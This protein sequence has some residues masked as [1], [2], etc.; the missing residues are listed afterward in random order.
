MKGSVSF[1]ALE[2]AI[3]PPK[4]KDVYKHCRD[5]NLSGDDDAIFGVTYGKRVQRFDDSN[6]QTLLNFGGLANTLHYW[7]Q[8]INHG[9]FVHE[10]TPDNSHTFLD[11]MEPLLMVLTHAD[12][13]EENS[14]IKADMVDIASE[15]GTGSLQLAWANGEQFAVQFGIGK[16]KKHLPRLVVVNNL[17]RDEDDFDVKIIPRSFQT[18]R[19]RLIKYIRDLPGIKGYKKHVSALNAEFVTT[20]KEWEAGADGKRPQSDYDAGD[21]KDKEKL[22]NDED[23]DKR[24]DEEG[25][26]DK[27]DGNADDDKDR[28]TPQDGEDED[29][30]TKGGLF[31]K[32][33][34]RL[35]YISELYEYRIFEHAE[36]ED[37]EFVKFE[38]DSM[39]QYLRTN[40]PLLSM[41]SQS[42]RH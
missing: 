37:K 29:D 9:I 3:S 39:M 21:E 38:I 15:I 16:E 7:T 33:S 20:Y 23:Q 6:P 19:T 12:E 25:G 8:S 22:L 35:E 26:E 24:E 32:I 14:K 40:F 31:S 11:R 28:E 34:S 30:T 41:V 2:M 42:P 36:N 17:E 1:A 10:L 18:K 5:K 4:N 27:G 13:K